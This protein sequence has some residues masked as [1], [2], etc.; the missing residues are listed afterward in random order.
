M[1]EIRDL[2]RIYWRISVNDGVILPFHDGFNFTKAFPFVYSCSFTLNILYKMA[3]M[4][5]GGRLSNAQK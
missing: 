1:L 2:Y 4:I 5:K 3:F